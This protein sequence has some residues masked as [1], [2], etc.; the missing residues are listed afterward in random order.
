M[1]G[2]RYP[3][4]GKPSTKLWVNENDDEF[5]SFRYSLTQLIRDGET[6]AYAPLAAMGWRSR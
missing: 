5:D 6:P 2:I 1:I 3:P 4:P